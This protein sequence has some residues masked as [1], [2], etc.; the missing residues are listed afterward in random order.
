M[1][2][3]IQD[4]DLLLWEAYASAGESGRRTGGRIM[5]HCLTDPSRRARELTREADEKD[6]AREIATL[7]EAELV[8]LLA[9]AAEVS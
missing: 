3:T 7:H 9:A 5:F 4:R 1:T 6:V 8:D 2:R